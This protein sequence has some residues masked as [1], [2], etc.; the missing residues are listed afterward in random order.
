MQIEIYQGQAKAHQAEYIAHRY[1]KDSCPLSNSDQ[2]WREPSGD[3]AK[4]LFLCLGQMV[5]TKL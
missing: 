3:V 1:N 2:I 5:W 4:F